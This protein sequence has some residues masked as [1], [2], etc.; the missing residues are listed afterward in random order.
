MGT[1][2]YFMYKQTRENVVSLMNPLLTDHATRVPTELSL[3]H[4]VLFF[5]Q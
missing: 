1:L 3:D 4:D 5:E 2:A